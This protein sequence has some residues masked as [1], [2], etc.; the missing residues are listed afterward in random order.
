MSYRNPMVYTGPRGP[1]ILAASMQNLINKGNQQMQAEEQR[2]RNEIAAM[3]ERE[4][5]I[6]MWNMEQV[7]KVNQ[8]QDLPNVDL[9]VKNMLAAQINYA[10]EAS[11]YLATQF[12]DDEKRAE[13]RDVITNY[14]SLLN[15]VTGFAGDFEANVQLWKE[16]YTQ[17]NQ[18]IALSGDPGTEEGRLELRENQ[19]LLDVLSGRYAEGTEID[20]TYDPDV[21]DLKMTITGSDIEGNTYNKVIYSK[22]WQRKTV[23]EG[24]EWISD[25]PKG[26]SVL[27]EKIKNQVDNQG[28]P[29]VNAAGNINE[30]LYEGKPTRDGK[31]MINGNAL[32]GALVSDAHQ[33]LY[34]LVYGNKGTQAIANFYNYRLR[35]ANGDNSFTSFEKLA[36][37]KAEQK[38]AEIDKNGDGIP[39]NPQDKFVTTNDILIEDMQAL[40]IDQTIASMPNIEIL[41]DYND[42]GV[43]EPELDSN[44]Q[45]QYYYK[46][47]PRSSSGGG[48]NNRPITEKR[49]DE[50][51]ASV[52]KA[53]EKANNATEGFDALELV[54]DL[55]N[56]NQYK[57]VPVEGSPFVYDV[58]EMQ[59][60]TRDGVKTEQPVKVEQFTIGD[61]N[62]YQRLIKFL[63][64][65]VI[66]TSDDYDTLPNMQNDFLTAAIEALQGSSFDK[67]VADIEAGISADTTDDNELLGA[68]NNLTVRAKDADGNMQSIK[69]PDLLQD[70]GITMETKTLDGNFIAFK[71]DGK[72]TR[73]KTN[74]GD[75][76]AQLVE[77]LKE[78]LGKNKTDAASLI[79]RYSN[80]N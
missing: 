75:F 60:V 46:V 56:I 18:D 74:S 21:K 58:M 8:I 63:N 24:I 69:L 62:E 10:A 57:F 68:L 16:R 67:L 53:Y 9:Q 30:G 22:E 3:Q 29:L 59:T 48:N 61:Q 12:G 5:K 70:A 23:G 52:D 49:A 80:Q 73:I 14:Q 41:G 66:P 65:G 25:I 72:T 43:F 7:N 13:A 38:N 47:A 77:Y 1:G 51:I 33:L 36:S 76:I 11:M 39:D 37:K 44:G 26:P 6:D 54:N 34:G 20:V 78:A 32:K 35:Q 71:K 19:W 45:L 27:H 79:A 64:K 17:L 50:I 2:R 31:Q 15:D 4:Y 28:A 55:Q 42:D 40:L